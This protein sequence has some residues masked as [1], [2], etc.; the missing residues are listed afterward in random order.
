MPV[1]QRRFA[2]KPIL[3]SNRN[4]QALLS[5][6][7]VADNTT[8]DVYV[9]QPNGDLV[10]RTVDLE[11]LVTNII[12]SGVTNYSYIYLNNRKVYKFYYDNQ[13]IRLDQELTE[14]LPTGVAYFKIRDLYDNE[15]YYVPNLTNIHYTTASVFPFANNETYIVEFFNEEF[16]MLTQINFTA[17]FAPAVLQS[18]DPLR[19]INHIQI[20]TNRSF[21]YQN[22]NVGSLLINVFVVYEDGSS[23]NVT[24]NN[25]LIVDNELIDTSTIGTYKITAQYYYDTQNGLYESAEKFIEV[26]P[27]IY[28]N[29]RDLVV[30]PRKVVALNDGR[31]SIILEV[32]AYYEDDLRQPLRMTEDCIVT[33]FNSILFNEMQHITV[34]LNLGHTNTWNQNYDI[35]VNDNGSATENKLRFKDNI[36]SVDP[37]YSVP[38]GAVK[39]RVRDPHDL[40]FWYTPTYADANY[41]TIFFDHTLLA[42]K[43]HTGSN[44]II[45][46]YATDLA[47]VDAVVFT[48]EY[49]PNI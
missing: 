13:V 3:Y 36:M 35:Q 29:I 27:D 23:Q 20:D 38:T 40:N 31:R 16:E 30:I 44:V 32:I 18:G 45:E 1:D 48:C 28:A 26:I 4:N 2:F 5:G 24:Y 19:V 6:E 41:D 22:E 34:S 33:G 7:V 39:Y 9:V 14:N 17:K 43:I 21:L 11:N 46:F 25:Q 8:G 42:D 37:L 49:D 10:S 47:L 15:K 12:N